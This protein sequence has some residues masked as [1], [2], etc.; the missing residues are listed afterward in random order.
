[1]S[2][3]EISVLFC[4][5][6]VETVDGTIKCSELDWSPHPV[7]E[8]VNL[9]HLVT[10]EKTNGSLSCHVVRVAPGCSIETHTHNPQWELHEIIQGS[11]QAMLD[12]E[13][14]TY[15]PGRSTVIPCGCE[16]SVR[17]GDDGLTILAKFFPALL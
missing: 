2:D 15:L 16:H 9:K 10:G 6:S 13:M 11:G 14:K 7:F 4:N 3:K 1:M 8:G 17:A 12:G 5:G